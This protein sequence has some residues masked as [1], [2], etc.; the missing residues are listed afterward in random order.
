MNNFRTALASLSLLSLLLFTGCTLTK[1]AQTG[2]AEW[3]EGD[4]NKTFEWG[5][6]VCH[7]GPVCAELELIRVQISDENENVSVRLRNRTHKG[8]AV[9]LS[10]EWLSEQGATRD[11]TRFHDLPI[12]PHQESE[13]VLH[14][15][16]APAKN[17]RIIVRGRR[18]L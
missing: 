2:V 4:Q 3:V 17:L 13:I 16:N 9:Q 14:G 10:L 11:Q 8:L 12:A 1:Q 6:F 15:P 18:A 7:E 5:E